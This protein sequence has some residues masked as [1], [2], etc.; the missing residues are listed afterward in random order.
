MLTCNIFT[1]EK[2]ISI[3]I[4]GNLIE[5]KTFSDIE[6]KDTENKDDAVLNCL[7]IIYKA[8]LYIKFNYQAKEVDTEL[9]I[10]DPLAYTLLK[11][12][13]EIIR[14]L[15]KATKKSI[16]NNELKLLL[17][18]ILF[19]IS[20]LKNIDIKLHKEYNTKG[21]S[22]IMNNN[23][24]FNKKQENT[25]SS[26]SSNFSDNFKESLKNNKGESDFDFDFDYE[27]DKKSKNINNSSDLELD[28]FNRLSS[29]RQKYINSHSDNDEQHSI[30]ATKEEN[31]NTLENLSAYE[32]ANKLELDDS[33]SLSNS[34]DNDFFI[35]ETTFANENHDDTLIDENVSPSINNI[36]KNIYQNNDTN[37]N[38][39]N[40][41]DFSD[42]NKD[43]D[44][45]ESN[46]SSNEDVDIVLEN[47]MPSTSPNHDLS[48]ESEVTPLVNADLPPTK[49][50]LPSEKHAPKKE[51]GDTV[52]HITDNINLSNEV[53]D[54]I[55]TKLS[56]E[57]NYM[58]SYIDKQIESLKNEIKKLESENLNIALNF[59]DLNIDES[60]IINSFKKSMELRLRLKVIKKSCTIYENIKIQLKKELSDF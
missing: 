20:S 15:S 24:K 2:A 40:N 12:N 47:E 58:E 42:N 33:V 50:E 18:S 37:A 27:E 1:K 3:F 34:E 51:D 57:F 21:D 30:V 9:I 55:K 41:E 39:T 25:F 35:D 52:S 10:D 11:P 17:G 29:M 45:F 8:S 19:E 38:I 4:D 16:S 43:N 7:K 54:N 6:Y 23:F 5:E 28:S 26:F 49:D 56:K 32:P 53:E 59:N 13:G 22:D 14:K 36:D 46:T 48:I 44:L 60:E 31:N